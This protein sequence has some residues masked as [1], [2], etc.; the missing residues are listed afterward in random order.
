MLKFQEFKSKEA[1]IKRWEL[2]KTYNW[3]S[4]F[5][6]MQYIANVTNYKFFTSRTI[7]QLKIEVAEN[8]KLDNIIKNVINN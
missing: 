3:E 4:D 7:E 5:E 8:I 1:N 6:A 2:L